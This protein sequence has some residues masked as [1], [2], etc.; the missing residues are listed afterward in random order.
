MIGETPSWSLGTSMPC[1]WMS[2]P[3]G[4]SLVISTSTSSPTSRSMRGPGTIPLY[5]H[6]WTIS[7][8]RTSQSMTDA[9]SSKRLVP[10]AWTSGAS[11]WLPSPSVSAGNAMIDSIIAWSC[12][13][14]LGGGGRVIGVPGRRRAGAH[15]R[16]AATDRQL[17]R[18][19][20]FGVSGDRAVDLVRAG[21]QL[22]D[23][24]LGARAG[25][26]IVGD[27]VLSSHREVV[28]HRP[29][30]ADRQRAGRG[31]LRGGQVDG[32]LGQVGFDRLPGHG[33][34]VVIGGAQSQ[35][36]ADDARQ[37]GEHGERQD[38]D[39][40][41]VAADPIALEVL[42][43][44]IESR[45]II[46][47]GV[48]H[49]SILGS[50]A[51]SRGRPTVAAVRD[52][53]PFDGSKLRRVELRHAL[54]RSVTADNRRDCGRRS[55]TSA[56]QVSVD[57]APTG[58]ERRLDPHERLARAVHE[59]VQVC[60]LDPR[61]HVRIGD[62][63]GPTD[64]EDA[65]SAAVRQLIVV[66]LEGDHS[67][68]GCRR[69][70][71]TW[72]RPEHNGSIDHPVVHGEDRRKRAKADSDPAD[73]SSS[74]ELPRRVLAQELESPI[75]NHVTQ[76]ACEYRPAVGPDGPTKRDEGPRCRRPR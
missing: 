54:E 76:F 73:L 25:I 3:M 41:G 59:R 69:H 6:A 62:D 50:H 32:E 27:Q 38:E 45:V 28:D 15:R 53:G 11:G 61:R 20:G 26:E 1:Q 5:A 43:E 40:P 9:V 21:L 42:L 47:H 64:G 60:C 55:I 52:V 72:R 34:G 44:G 16:S 36:D 46:G 75:N 24:E 31:D 35:T 22:A 37:G 74:Q 14:A 33:A 70:L 13:C 8:G 30:V 12:C 65:P 56:G 29:V 66:D 63:F 48:G 67:T 23:V 51:A 71:R 18:H 7:P 58:N 2:V 57:D 10:S 39:G 17:G 4:S 49:G 68:L 19:A